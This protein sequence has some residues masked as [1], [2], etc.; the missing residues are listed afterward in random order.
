MRSRKHRSETEWRKLVEQQASSGL[1]GVK[2]CQQEGLSR[3]TF[4][5]HRKSL[6]GKVADGVAGQFIKVTP[7]P[8]QMMPVQP[9][10]VLHYR[11][12]QL[13]LPVGANPTWVA[14]LMKALA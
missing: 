7:G 1:N 12:S 14:E 10:V 3:K 6:K 5:R 4:Y 11:D 2:F 13:Q 8:V 9:T